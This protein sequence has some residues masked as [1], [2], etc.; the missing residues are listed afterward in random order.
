ME[1]WMYWAI[2]GVLLL[3]CAVTLLLYR[4]YGGAPLLV[5]AIPAGLLGLFGL[6]IAA[7]Q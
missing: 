5:I 2:P 1:T 6:W 4:R 7:G 3:V